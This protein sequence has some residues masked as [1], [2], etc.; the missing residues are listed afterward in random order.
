M[1]WQ[2]SFPKQLKIPEVASKQR[3]AGEAASAPAGLAS[4]S[5]LAAA[6]EEQART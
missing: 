2:L 5:V 6:F 4:H 3:R 1:Q